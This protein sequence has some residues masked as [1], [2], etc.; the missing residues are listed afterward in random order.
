MTGCPERANASKRFADES[1]MKHTNQRRNSVF[2]RFV[3][4]DDLVA[5]KF[6]LV[7]G[8]FVA[9]VLC[10]LA[11]D[12][13]Q[14]YVLDSAR[15]Y[16]SGEGFWS[17]GQINAVHHLRHYGIS[18]DEA[19][20]QNFLDGLA[21]SLGD[22]Q[23]RL[24]LQASPPDI[25]S[26]REGFLKGRNHPD[27]VDNMISFFLNF[28]EIR[29]MKK[30]I[31]IWTEG[32]QQIDKLIQLGEQLYKS[33]HAGQP[34]PAHVR[35]IMARLDET[36]SQL[37]ELEDRFSATLG[38]AARWIKH[39]TGLIMF[40]ST[41]LLLVVG[42]ILSR[43]IVR[44]IRATQLALEHSEARFRHVVESNI[45][46]IMFW[47]ADGTII[48]ANNAFLDIIGYSRDE[49]E[50][51]QIS[52]KSITTAEGGLEDDR[53]I[54][55]IRK[56]GV[57]S[58]FEKEYRHKDGHRVVV[59]L[60]GASFDDANY[61]GVCFVL[62]ISE[63]KR[64]EKDQKLASAVFHAA[65]EAIIVT[66][67]TPC[68][69]AVNPAFT[70]ITGY[71]AEEVLGKNPAI[72]SSGEQDT[73][74]YRA[75]WESLKTKGGWKGEIR[76]RR[77]NG[78]VY[79]EWLS[80]SA[81]C[82]DNG[83]VSEYV[84]LFSDITEQRELEEQLKQSQKMEA[85]GTLV[86]GI[87]HDFNNTLAAMQG[88]IY[89]AKQYCDDNQQIGEKLS[90]IEK[91]GDHSAEIVRQLL[92]FARKGIVQM[93][94]FSL[95]DLLKEHE[96]SHAIIPEGIEFSLQLCDDD[97]SIVGDAAQLQQALLNL[98]NNAIDAVEDTTEPEIYCCLERYVPDAA[99]LEKYPELASG[100][101]AHVMVCD[102]GCGIL[103]KD[104]DHIF[105][106]FF[107][108]KEVD[109]GT[110]LG[111][112]MVY[113]SIQTH[114]GAIDVASGIGK[115]TEMHLYLPLWDEAVMVRAGADQPEKDQ[116]AAEGKETILLVDDDSSVRKI[117]F[118]VLSS[119]GY[120]VL[121]AEN[122]IAAL[123]CFVRH[124]DRIGLVITDIVMPGMGG[125]DLAEKIRQK[126]KRLSIIFITGYDPVRAAVPAHLLENSIILTKPFSVKVLLAEA[127][128]MLDIKARS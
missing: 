1:S 57:C 86:G 26:A 84:A 88:N 119:V 83:K 21:P 91:L 61:G 71:S 19:D 49:L 34:D 94:P 114:R 15:A 16:V 3:W 47:K 69:K 95:S 109:R 126:A 103:E 24:A 93:K 102:N 76:N 110:G 111:L 60:G 52:W 33:V 63:R 6:Y 113:G 97:L 28:G 44:G 62:D 5:R 121:T 18:F 120:E 8:L 104:M 36:D 9:I 105:E 106:P 59:Y 65:N 50:A 116:V 80:I 128:R 68:I 122:G 22:R 101:L 13:F 74:F 31:A 73:E 27:D 41:M 23:A 77:K 39:L 12:R 54:Q 29:E 51:G 48:D 66:D 96:S 64:A 115:G 45:I 112:S 92:T 90:V 14:A 124:G 82:D 53:T 2:G 125:F 25:Q 32:D 79:Q 100:P 56:Q 7:V 4:D 98:L 117:C 107:T 37:A 30:A 42:I 123:E 72:L 78:D 75:M 81:I 46:G 40:V 17:K 87:A 20:Y 99:F 67:K 89:L 70:Q 35:Q 11:L 118:E 43:Q 38:Y 85:I 58:P 108:T 55:K 127:S 10:L